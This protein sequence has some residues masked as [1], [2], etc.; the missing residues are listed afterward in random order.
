MTQLDIALRAAGAG[1]LLLIAL[2]LLRSVP[3]ASVARWFL[4]FALGVSG[5]LRVNTGFDAA[6]LPH[7]LWPHATE[8]RPQRHPGIA[9]ELLFRAFLF[10]FLFRY[11]RWGF[12]PAALLSALVFGAEHLYQGAS[13]PEALAIFALTGL[14]GVWWSWLLVEWRWN[15]WVP[16]AFHVLLNTY[17]TM[18]DV[19]DNALG[20]TMEIL[21]RLACIA[22]SVGV[23]VALARRRGGLRLSGRRWFRGTEE[24]G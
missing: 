13:A 4:P 16:V 17:W 12:L 3:R 11:A 21:L 15:L 1:M 5:F 2:A 22:L 6:E 10:G 14:G 20:G 8:H 9:E 7:P 19:A 18:F 23:T 24:A